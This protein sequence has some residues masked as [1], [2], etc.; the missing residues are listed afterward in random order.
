MMLKES[1]EVAMCCKT[2]PAAKAW[3]EN[4]RANTVF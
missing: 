2:H 4:Q 3:F 1:I